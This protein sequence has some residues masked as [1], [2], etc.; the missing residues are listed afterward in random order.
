MLKMRHKPQKFEIEKKLFLTQKR[1]NFVFH[2]QNIFKQT[3][4]DN[5]TKQALKP[6]KKSLNKKI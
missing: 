6:Q 2:L 4:L 1:Q 3:M 5:N